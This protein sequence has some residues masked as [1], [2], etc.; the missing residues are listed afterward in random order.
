LVDRITDGMTA[1]PALTGWIALGLFLAIGAEFAVNESYTARLNF[2]VFLPLMAAIVAHRHG[3]CVFA[4]LTVLAIPGMSG[5]GWNITDRLYIVFEFPQWVF[6]LSVAAAVAFCR[7]AIPL[8]KET[9]FNERFRWARWLMLAALVL[10]QHQSLAFEIEFSDDI[11]LE[12]NF[13]AMALLL[14]LAVSINW[15]GLAAAFSERVLVPG[16]RIRN[17]VKAAVWLLLLPAVAV[18]VSWELG[19]AL[20]GGMGFGDSTS[21]ILAL[22]LILTAAGAVDW[23]GAVLVAVALI[24]VA[25]L[26]RP[27]YE[28]V[29]SAMTLPAPPTVAEEA[30]GNDTVLVEQV[31]V[32]GQ[33]WRGDSLPRFLSYNAWYG[34]VSACCFGL[35]GAALAPAW[36]R[37][38]PALLATRRTAMLLGVAVATAFAV[39]PFVD[40][41]LETPWYF[42]I[43][44]TALLMGYRWRYRGLILGPAVLMFGYLAMGFALAIPAHSVPSGLTLIDLGAIAFP[45]AF[46]GL[47]LTRYRP[48]EGGASAPVGSGES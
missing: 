7:P 28:L 1:R 9:L 33:R 6:L 22:V 34:I 40:G 41:S 37:K 31:V 21:I 32:T 16:H 45:A 13:P 42:V 23:R 29:E 14:L 11:F 24:V 25:E 15:R 8:S 5:M 36:R 30:A 39:A 19:Y 38:D 12:L 35:L 46:I 47:L 48:I 43:V 10:M 44:I 3:K 2:A 26:T 20:F 17:A 18:H 4:I 27:V